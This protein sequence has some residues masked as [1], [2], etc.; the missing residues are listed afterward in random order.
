MSCRLGCS[1]AFINLLNKGDQMSDS[2]Q[3]KQLVSGKIKSQN[4]RLEEVRSDLEE[5]GST[6]GDYQLYFEGCMDAL[7]AFGI[8]PSEYKS[9]TMAYEANDAEIRL[10]EKKIDLQNELASE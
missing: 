2:N 10:I 8:D 4:E 1:P 7:K 9:L 5:T 3:I 6:L